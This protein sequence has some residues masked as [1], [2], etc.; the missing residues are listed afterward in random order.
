[1]KELNKAQVAA[2]FAQEAVLMGSEDMVPGF[3][4]AALFGKDAVEHAKRMDRS[5]PARYSNGY[6]VGGLHHI[7]PDIPGLPGRRQLPQCTAHETGGA[8]MTAN[9][10]QAEIV[11]LLDHC[12]DRQLDLVLHMVCA[13][14]K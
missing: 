6:G 7:C 12:N 5:A 1:M 13:I 11:R 3:R 14:L 8:E 2:L 10:I 9:E 4:A